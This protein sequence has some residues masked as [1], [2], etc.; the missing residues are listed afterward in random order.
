MAFGLAALGGFLKG[1]A[2][3]LISGGSALLGGLMSDRST[4]SANDANTRL[5]Y[6]MAKNG[7]RYRMEDAKAAGVHPVYALGA[8]TYQ[9][10]PS[11]VGGSGLGTGVAA[12]GQDIGRSIQATRTAPERMQVDL[13]TQILK[14][15]LD[16]KLIDNQIRASQ[17]AREQRGQVGPAFPTTSGS[18]IE[19]QGDS[20]PRVKDSPLERVISAK[21]ARSQEPA[22]VTEVGYLQTP[23]GQMPVKSMD[24]T[25][26][27]EDDLIGNL[28]WNI[29]NRLMPSLGLNYNPPAGS[30]GKW[31]YNP[32]T[33]QYEEVSPSV[34][35]WTPHGVFNRLKRRYSR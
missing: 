33:Q 28:V 2:P 7:I 27:L 19:G 25:Q 22:P 16:G 29:R 4:S 6:D 13:N 17:L 26:R 11:I 20:G 35:E 8:Q 30:N 32:V 14:A 5:Q 34:Y 1:N 24:A 31:M 15:D 9:A 3:A 10:S 23:N 12:M 18:L 21:G